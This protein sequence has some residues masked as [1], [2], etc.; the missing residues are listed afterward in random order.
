M[1]M[2]A[3]QQL[4][5]AVGRKLQAQKARKLLVAKG[6]KLQQTQ[7]PPSCL[8]WE[9]MGQCNASFMLPNVSRYIVSTPK[10]QPACFQLETRQCLHQY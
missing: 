5:G 1:R 3:L 8:D 7:F 2:Q 10:Q 9:Q 4:L 6:R